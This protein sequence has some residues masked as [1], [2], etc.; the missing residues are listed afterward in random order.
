MSIDEIRNYR[1][2][3]PFQPFVIVLSDGQ[4][5]SVMARQRIGFAPWGKVGVFEGS[6]FHLLA[7]A[8]IAAVKLGV[9]RPK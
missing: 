2:A 6:K 8:E 7:P 4:A 9:L 1:N 5:V 3:V